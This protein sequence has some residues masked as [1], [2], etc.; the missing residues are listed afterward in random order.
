[1]LTQQSNNLLLEKNYEKQV[2]VG[3]LPT[4][5]HQTAEPTVMGFSKVSKIRI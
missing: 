3:R 2:K 1:M 5:S 4:V